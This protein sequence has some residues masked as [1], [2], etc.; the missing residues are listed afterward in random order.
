MAKVYAKQIST[1]YADG[2]NKKSKM[3]F[4]VGDGVEFSGENG[5]LI[6][7]EKSNAAIDKKLERKL[8]DGYI[9]VSESDVING[10]VE[11][12]AQKI[13]I[14]GKQYDKSLFI[15]ETF[16]AVKVRTGETT[17]F[18][19]IIDVFKEGWDIFAKVEDKTKDYICT[20]QLTLTAIESWNSKSIGS[21][22]TINGISFEE[23]LMELKND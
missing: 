5:K 16:E 10:K 18:G 14:G 19:K 23:F 6:R 11:I 20:A 3:L 22:R 21:I 12:Q 15:G 9:F 4:V 17:L 13:E 8:R 1:S 2:F 7:K